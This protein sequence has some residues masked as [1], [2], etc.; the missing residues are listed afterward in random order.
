MSRVKVSI[1]LTAGRPSRWALPR[2]LVLAKSLEWGKLLQIPL[3]TSTASVCMTHDFDVADSGC[4]VEALQF[5]NDP[6]H[7]LEQLKKYQSVC[8]VQRQCSIISS[9]RETVQPSWT[10][11]DSDTSQKQ[12]S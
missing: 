10:H 1:H 12:D 5:L 6:S 3:K 2:I 11:A 8:Q 4:K 9:C 7:E